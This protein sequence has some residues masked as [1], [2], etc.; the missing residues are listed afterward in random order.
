M[1]RLT[2]EGV[3]AAK[4]ILRMRVPL[5]LLIRTKPKYAIN[6]GFKNTARQWWGTLRLILECGYSDDA[7]CSGE[8]FDQAFV[9]ITPC[10]IGK[11]GKLLL[12]S[13]L[14]DETSVKIHQTGH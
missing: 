14:R 3:L 1:P 13:T 10:K 11:D 12:T 4:S 8:L 9:I 2:F 7:D 5:T 6:A